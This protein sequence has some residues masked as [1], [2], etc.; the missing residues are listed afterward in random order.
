MDALHV[1]IETTAGVGCCHERNDNVV[2]VV[3]ANKFPSMLIGDCK[4]IG[5]QHFHS[6]DLQ[7]W[8]IKNGVQLNWTFGYQILKKVY[9]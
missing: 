6:P 2:F 4:E 3:W 7:L 9:V 1:M 8:V 5:G